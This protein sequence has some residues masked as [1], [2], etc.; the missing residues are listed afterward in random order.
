MFELVF[1]RR[2]AMAHR[3]R[4]D[5][6]GRCAVPHGHNEIVVARLVP[7]RAARLDGSANMVEPFERAKLRWHAWIDEQVDHAFQLGEA[8]P[9]IAYFAQAEPH[10][11]ARLLITPGDPTTELLAVL[12]KAKLECF[13][14]AE[15]GRLAC[16]E[17]AIEETPTNKVVFSGAVTDALPAGETGDRWWARAD[18]SINDLKTAALVRARP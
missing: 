8:D 12:F 4:G 3:L 15:G 17:I 1:T 13:L 6:S 2:Y 5:P 10:R 9:L 11:L 18:A 14:A 7:V 16:A